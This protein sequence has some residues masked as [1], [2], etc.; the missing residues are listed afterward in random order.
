MVT[1]GLHT[2][3]LLVP[4]LIWP[5]TVVTMAPRLRITPQMYWSLLY[6]SFSC[7]FLSQQ[8]PVS[9]GYSFVPPTGMECKVKNRTLPSEKGCA[10]TAE[11]T[12]LFLSVMKDP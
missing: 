11:A 9:L 7:S 3:P 4:F 6:F 10:P 12:M 2:F 1:M 5:G 8:F